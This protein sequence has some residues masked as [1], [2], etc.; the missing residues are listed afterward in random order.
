ML[1]LA[2][3]DLAGWHLYPDVGDHLVD[4]VPAQAP[5]TAEAPVLLPEMSDASYQ[6]R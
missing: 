2:P 4:A 1:W 3:A 6:W 5:P